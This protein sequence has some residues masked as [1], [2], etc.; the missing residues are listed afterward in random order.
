MVRPLSFRAH[1]NKPGAI[2][3]YMTTGVLPRIGDPLRPIYE[4]D[5]L[6]KPLDLGPCQIEQFWFDRN[7]LY[8]TRNRPAVMYQPIVDVYWDL[9]QTESADRDPEVQENY[10]LAKLLPNIRDQKAR[11]VFRDSVPS[12]RFDT[13]PKEE[14]ATDLEDLLSRNTQAMSVPDFHRSTAD[15]LGPPEYA[16]E[17][18]ELYDEMAEQLLAPGRERLPISEAE[19]VTEVRRRWQEWLTSIGRRRR[20]AEREKLMLDI[21]SHESKAA[22]H[23]AYSLVWSELIQVLSRNHRLDERG[24]RFHRFWHSTMAQRSQAYPTQYAHLFHGHIFGLHPASSMFIQTATGKRLI[25]D[26]LLDASREKYEL[27]LSGI[28]LAIFHYSSVYDERRHDRRMRV[29]NDLRHI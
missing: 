18:W 7:K 15:V 22:F 10:L 26:W 16:E 19:A 12:R 5:L 11:E 8:P 23:R 13:E 14:S 25:G 4:L 17:D 1:I 6:H 24:A 9:C 21:L 29:S 27:L 3:Q 20:G 2:T 28:N